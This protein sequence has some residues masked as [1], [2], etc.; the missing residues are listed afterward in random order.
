MNI[1]EAL[2]LSPRQIE[3]TYNEVA[4]EAMQRLGEQGISLASNKPEYEYD[5]QLPPDLD[6]LTNDELASLMVR[7]QE[8]T[9][10]LNGCH[11]SANASKK[12]A[13]RSLRS[14]KNSIEQERGKEVVLS[15]PRFVEADVKFLFHELKEEIISD[16]LKDAKASYTLMS[17]LIALREQDLQATQKRHVMASTTVRKRF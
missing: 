1:K 14:I 2:R 6:L 4:L 9:R 17:R 8:W 7:H 10:Y 5:G 11:S 15:D 16:L 3:A 12:V 13:Q